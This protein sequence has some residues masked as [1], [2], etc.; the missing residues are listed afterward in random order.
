MKTQ[1]L[2]DLEDQAEI[3]LGII[4]TN[5]STVFTISNRNAKELFLDVVMLVNEVIK[6]RKEVLKLKLELANEGER[7]AKI[8]NTNQ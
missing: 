8:N 3:A 1:N 4:H 7:N 6:L 5:N 2:R